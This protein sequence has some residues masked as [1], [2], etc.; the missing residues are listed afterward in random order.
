[1]ASI[2]ITGAGRGIGAVIATHFA[3]QGF[4]PILLARHEDQLHQVV[5]KCRKYDV[6]AL[7]LACDVADYEQCGQMLEQL[8]PQVDLQ[9]AV[10]NHGLPYFQPLLSDRERQWQRVIDVNLSASIHLAQKLIPYLRKSTS[11]TRSLTF[12]VSITGK[13][14]PG[15]ATAYCAS[16]HGLLGFAH[17]LF[18]EVREYGVKVASLCPGFVNTGMVNEAPH[19]SPD[20]M[21]QP[22][23]IAEA[24]DYVHQSSVHVCPVEL[25]LRPQY[26]PYK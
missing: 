21:I 7:P 14:T 22:K 25:T 3:A 16:K 23:D 5:Q 26:T 18:E 10:I 20:D 4:Q 12:T 24:I 1:M 15:N 9:A 6:E 19:L 8:L 13:I 11:Q 2:L 17:S